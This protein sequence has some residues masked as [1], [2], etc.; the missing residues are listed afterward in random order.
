MHYDPKLPI[1][2]AGDASN[3]R[4]GAVLSHVDAKGQEHPIAF[5]SRTLSQ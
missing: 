1:R 4:I 3:Y 5:V 2:L